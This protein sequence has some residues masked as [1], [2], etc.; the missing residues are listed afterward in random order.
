MTVSP[1]TRPLAPASVTSALGVLRADGHRISAARRLVL[2]AL[3]AADGPVSADRLAGG[4]DGRLPGSDL[5]SLYRNLDTL[6]EAG[7]VEHL[8][9]PHGPGLY[10]LTGRADGWAAC[11]ACGRV[12]RAR[13]RRRRPAARGGARRDRLRGRPR[14]LPARRRLPGVRGGAV[15]SAG[16]APAS[17]ARGSAWRSP[18][19]TSPARRCCSRSR[20]ATAGA[21]T[22]GVGLTAYTL[23]L[24]HAFDADH[25]AAIDNTTRK[26]MSDGRRPLSVG[27]FFAL[28]HSTVVL[29]LAA[30]AR[31]RRA[32]ARRRRPGRGLGAAADDRAGR[33]A[34]L[35]LVPVRDR[36]PQP[37][38]ADRR[39][40]RATARTPRRADRGPARGGARAA[41]AAAAGST[42]A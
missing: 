42:A 4:L 34:R 12:E 38:A 2:E 39:R 11:E 20:T 41:R 33:D 32:R 28:G 13:P 24:R 35:G 9:V 5:A 31:R 23:G 3:F 29:V 40:A 27:F 6:A 15:M 17:S 22:A 26:L 37:A 16:D 10:V 18:R 8:H 7:I 1:D 21:I 14:P 36:D 25:I 30:A 19:C